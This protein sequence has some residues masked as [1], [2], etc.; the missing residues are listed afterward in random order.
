MDDEKYLN[1]ADVASDS[2]SSFGSSWITDTNDTGMFLTAEN[3][4]LPCC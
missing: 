1:S 4:T 2:F 3:K